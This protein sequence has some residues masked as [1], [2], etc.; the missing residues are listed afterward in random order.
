M[1]SVD[2]TG[3]DT[4]HVFF[5]SLYRNVLF[6]FIITNIT[7]SRARLKCDTYDIHLTAPIFFNPQVTMPCPYL[8]RINLQKRSSMTFTLASDVSKTLFKIVFF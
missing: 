1:I 4:I 8:L 3:E 7:C 6:L 2:R 5:F